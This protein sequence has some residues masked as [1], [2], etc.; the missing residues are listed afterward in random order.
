MHSNKTYKPSIFTTIANHIDRL[1]RP[2]QK[3]ASA[4]L[5]PPVLVYFYWIKLRLWLMD[6][7]HITTIWLKVLLVMVLSYAAVV[8]IVH[9]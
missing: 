9:R 5:I 3:M 1:P 7:F 2:L 8:A 6:E 4:L